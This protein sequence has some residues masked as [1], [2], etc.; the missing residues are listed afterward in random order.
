[1]TWVVSLLLI[2]VGL[3]RHCL[4]RRMRALLYRMIVM[5]LQMP[6]KMLA[7][8]DELENEMKKQ[9]MPMTMKNMWHMMEKRSR[10]WTEVS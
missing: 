7:V 3:S 10:G 1:M 4:T 2:V 5:M 6:K 9:M 8:V